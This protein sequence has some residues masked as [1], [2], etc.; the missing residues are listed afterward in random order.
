MGFSRFRPTPSFILV[1][2]LP[3]SK[4]R[5]KNICVED[6]LILLDFVGY[7]LCKLIVHHCLLRMKRGWEWKDGLYRGEDD[8]NRKD[9]SYDRKIIL[10]FL[11]K[12][13]NWEDENTQKVSTTSIGIMRGHRI[14]NNFPF[15]MIEW[16]KS[17][18]KYFGLDYLNLTTRKVSVLVNVWQIFSRLL[19]HV[20][21]SID[22]HFLLY[23]WQIVCLFC[24]DT[25]FLTF[26]KRT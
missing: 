19:W 24:C 3:F 11:R 12:N 26:Q 1:F 20:A 14:S 16:G 9:F 18:R 4:N 13:Q 5:R 6:H 15:S 21:P 7:Y 8:K 22:S 10:V 25:S 17:K 23:D 2:F